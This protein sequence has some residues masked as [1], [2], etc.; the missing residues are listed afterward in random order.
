MLEVRE[1]SLG[2]VCVRFARLAP[3]PEHET[4]F[5]VGPES[6]KRLGYL[7]RTV[8]AF[9]GSL[10]ISTREVYLTMNRW[11]RVLAVIIA[12]GMLGLPALG[13]ATGLQVGDKAPTFS[14]PS[15][16]AESISLADYLGRKPVVLF[17]YIAAFGR[18]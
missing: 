5:P 17:F 6:P 18:S 13:W 16:T 7:A 4:T 8:D 11:W 2:S 9:L 1:A 10:H 15:T 12:G 14:L 3:S